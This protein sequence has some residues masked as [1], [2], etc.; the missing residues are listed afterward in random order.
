MY[1]LL[2]LLHATVC[3]YS[4]CYF[5]PCISA[6][7]CDIITPILTLRKQVIHELLVHR[8]CG[9]VAWIVALIC[10]HRCLSPSVG[11]SKCGLVCHS[12]WGRWMQSWKLLELFRLF[13]HSNCFHCNT[14]FESSHVRPTL[15][16]WRHLQYMVK[17][18]KFYWWVM[19]SCTTWPHTGTGTTYPSTK[20]ILVWY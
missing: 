15:K 17:V 6:K 3:M 10:V 11:N 2:P 12:G 7:R 16:R 19:S 14:R 13:L 9:F 4:I 5:T 20:K 1:P 8:T 18:G